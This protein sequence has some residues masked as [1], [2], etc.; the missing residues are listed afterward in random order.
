[1]SIPASRLK[2]ELLESRFV[3][4]WKVYGE[5]AYAFSLCYKPDVPTV[6][7]RRASDWAITKDGETIYQY[8]IL[9]DVWVEGSVYG[10][11]IRRRQ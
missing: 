1:M 5:P 6:G 3:H 8:D 9:N 4:E 10:F 7:G 2:Y 11:R